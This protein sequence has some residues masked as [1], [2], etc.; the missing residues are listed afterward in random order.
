LPLLSFILQIDWTDL[1][2]TVDDFGRTVYSFPIHI[3]ILLGVTVLFMLI[4]L[5]LLGVIMASRIYKTKRVIR[6][7]MLLKKYQPVFR[8]L[9]FEE[10]IES[11]DIPGLF[12]SVDLKKKFHR[13]TLLDEIV[14]LHQ[15][16]TGETAERLEEIFVIL[17]FHSDSLRKLTN[18]RWYVAAKGMRE[19]ALMNVKSAYPSIATY[20]SS[21]NEIL[22]ME[23][24]ISLMKLSD[25][26]PLAFL[27]KETAPLT[28]WDTANIY[29]MLSKMP[30]TMIP[31]FSKW[32][33]SSNPDV[34]IFCIR[35]IGTFKQ[36]ESVNTLLLLLK[37]ED[38]RIRVAV[39]RALRE[40]NAAA[41]EQ[42]L[43]DIYSLE[44]NNV[45]NEI[46]R[47]LEVIGSSRSEQLFEKI[48]AQPIDDYPI[49]IQAV[50]SLLALGDR[51]IRSVERIFE[52]AGPQLQLVI[53]H[54]KDKR[55]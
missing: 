50:R 29:T 25:E 55:L 44:D 18:R 16:F 26:D 20:L 40:L 34:V 24:R 35:M 27:S 7:K 28:D 51:G 23:S 19:L 8:K 13:E 47:T 53:R 4:I 17:N 2:F 12:D 14:H 30:E 52:A 31:D 6:K 48:L 10:G 1:Q 3:R 39:I 43:L 41:G 32:L 38:P 33:N 42:T 49:A 21:K 45:R 54:A 9:L 22:R 36:Q 5:I 15:N 37:S 46:L 11:G